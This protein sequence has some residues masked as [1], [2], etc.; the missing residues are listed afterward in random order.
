MRARRAPR[1]FFGLD[2]Q[3]HIYLCP[4]TLF[5]FY[6]DFDAVL[7]DILEKDSKAELVLLEGRVSN[8]T[9]RLK[10]RFARTLGENTARVHFLPAQPNP[11]FLQLLAVADVMLDPFP[12]GGGN[13]SYEAF[14][15]DTPI[16]T[17]PSP[18]LRGRITLALYRKM[19]W[20]DCVVASGEQ[21]VDLAVRLA[22]D[23][24]YHESIRDKIRATNH[25][26]FEDLEEVRSLEAF[27]REAMESGPKK[28]K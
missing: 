28:A 5:K 13:T 7:A 23:R 21:Y 14:A 18:F 15:V 22:T 10:K 3:R 24:Q 17:W 27:L 11:E 16:V 25:V 8:W 12:F 9:A 4:Q 2:P 1:E 26:L 19:G 6:P 20:T